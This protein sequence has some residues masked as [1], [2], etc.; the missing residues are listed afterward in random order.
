MYVC[1]GVNYLGISLYVLRMFSKHEVIGWEMIFE[2]SLYTY[3]F[4]CI[5]YSLALP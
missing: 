2:I 1:V 3:F 4:P 5:K